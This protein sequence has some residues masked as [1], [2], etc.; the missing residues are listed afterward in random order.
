VS[1]A[2]TILQFIAFVAG[3]AKLQ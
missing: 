1:R 3:I 2:H